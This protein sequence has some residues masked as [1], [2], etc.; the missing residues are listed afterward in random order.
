MKLTALIAA[1]LLVGC[2][3][4]P[5]SRDYEYPT[6]ISGKE[7]YNYHCAGCHKENGVG[8]FL[9]AIPAL[10]TTDYTYSA[11]KTYAVDVDHKKA[12]GSEAEMPRFTHMDER[13]AGM[14][15]IYIRRHLRIKDD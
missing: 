13:T 8:Q 4:D 5:S 12:K 6:F 2:S 7:A 3:A 14:I 9:K 11:I 15:A 1:L 10:S